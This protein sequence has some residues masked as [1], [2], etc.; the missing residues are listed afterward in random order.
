MVAG[1]M[2]HE[3]PHPIDPGSFALGATL[4]RIETKLDMLTQAVRKLAAVG[5][6]MGVKLEHVE[7]LSEQ[8]AQALDIGREAGSL[9]LT[10]EPPRP[11]T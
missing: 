8:I 6:A 5:G 7:T 4:C 1:A 10:A 3:H 2:A 11:E 9:T